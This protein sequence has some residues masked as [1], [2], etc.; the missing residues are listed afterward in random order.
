ML[1]LPKESGNRIVRVAIGKA[2]REYLSLFTPWLGGVEQSVD[3]SREK[4]GVK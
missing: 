3:Y 4:G 2:G 1:R